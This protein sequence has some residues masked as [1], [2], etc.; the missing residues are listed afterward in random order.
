MIGHHFYFVYLVFPSHHIFASPYTNILPGRPSSFD[1]CSYIRKEIEVYKPYNH[2]QHNPTLS[3]HRFEKNFLDLKMDTPPHSPSSNIKDFKGIL[4]LS[5]KTVEKSKMT[6]LDR[7]LKDLASK[8][9]RSLIGSSGQ[10]HSSTFFRNQE[11]EHALV[12][13]VE[14]LEDR[15]LEPKQSIWALAVLKHLQG[16][17]PQGELK[18]I[19]TDMTQGPICRAALGLS[20]TQ[21][22]DLLGA[23]QTLWMS[24]VEPEISKVDLH[25]A[26]AFL[27]LE[28]IETLHLY[29]HHLDKPRLFGV[30]MY[31]YLLK[32][33]LPM[34]KHEVKLFG[35]MLLKLATVETNDGF[36]KGFAY[37]HI[38]KM[39][40][41]F[42]EIKDLIEFESSI[43]ASFKKGYGERVL[44]IMFYEH[45]EELL[46]D[47]WSF[48]L[49]IYSTPL[50]TMFDRLYKLKTATVQDIDAVV[51]YLVEGK[52]RG[53]GSSQDK[54][55]WRYVV[56]KQTAEQ[57]YAILCLLRRIAIQIPGA[58]KYLESQVE[59]SGRFL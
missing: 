41:V 37:L 51:K 50:E 16:Y 49:K 55:E 8:I 53:H 19:R 31:N 52:Y 27:I 57:E 9:N 3:R 44:N 40:S 33:K 48:L 10:F 56:P 54:P 46:E 39:A 32:R 15:S 5:N 11:F 25:L 12:T 18:P 29:L 23:S 34:N 21:D 38:Y 28:T 26:Q 22:L 14:I 7:D 58:E 20:L 4:A 6:M 43:N 47:I 36:E 59:W 35:R 24:N 17:L 2:D 45:N 13:A 42:P 30:E 1:Q